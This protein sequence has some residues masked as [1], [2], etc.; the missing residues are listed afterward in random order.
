MGIVNTVG[1][2]RDTSVLGSTLMHEHVFVSTPEIRNDYPDLSWDGERLEKVKLAADKLRKAKASGIDT[3]VD[4]TVLGL[5]RDVKS[6]QVVLSQVDI[7]IIAATGIYAY[8]HLP[9][10]LQTRPPRGP[11]DRD[12]MV[13]IFVRDISVG[14]SDSGVRAAILKC[15]TD[16]PGV[17]PNNERVLRAV[18]KA[19]RETGVPISTH[20]DARLQNGRDQQRIFREEGVDLARVIIG[21]SGDTKDLDYLQEIMD[22]GSTI[23]CDRFGLYLPGALTF[24]DRVDVVV[25]LC[26]KGYAD[27]LVLSHDSICYD[28]TRGTS[29]VA[30]LKWQLTHVPADVIPALKERGVSDNQVHQMLVDNP[31]R[32]FD[33][34]EAY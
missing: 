3:I 15:T 27:R 26:A 19:H 28:D 31:K 4:L 16:K 22:E 12:V 30:P 7:N 6:I 24:D 23:G 14:I 17:T 8:D 21:H 9:H 20:S 25:A 13:D 11:S 34:T 1:G 33:Q 10:Y 32:I 2:P 29:F 5:N 18:A